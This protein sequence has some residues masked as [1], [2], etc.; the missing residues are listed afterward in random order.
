[1]KSL[2]NPLL[3][4]HHLCAPCQT[5]W[6]SHCFPLSMQGWVSETC[7]FQCLMGALEDERTRTCGDSPVLCLGSLSLLPKHGWLLGWLLGAGARAPSCWLLCRCLQTLFMPCLGGQSKAAFLVHA[8]PLVP[9]WAGV[10]GL[11]LTPGLG[12]Q[13]FSLSQHL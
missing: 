11:S 7:E 3:P 2:R 6:A 9:V 12:Q 10:L 4:S 8:S 1:M 13:M 5:G